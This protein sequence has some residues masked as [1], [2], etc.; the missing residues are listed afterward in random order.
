MPSLYDMGHRN[1]CCVTDIMGIQ[2]LPL[3]SMCD[4]GATD[5]GLLYDTLSHGG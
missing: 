3:T 2:F 4:F 1:E 5:L